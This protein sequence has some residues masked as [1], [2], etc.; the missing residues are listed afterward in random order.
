MGAE[1][2]KGQDVKSEHLFEYADRVEYIRKYQNQQIRQIKVN[3][4]RKTDADLIAFLESKDNIAGY[5]KALIRS[6]ME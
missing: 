5:I 4:N 6:D 2:R 1:I 3:L